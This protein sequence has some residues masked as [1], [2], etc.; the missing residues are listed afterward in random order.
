MI[1]SGIQDIISFCPTVPPMIKIPD[2]PGTREPAGHK[3][4]LSDYFRSR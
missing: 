4:N 2:T 3:K 1:Q